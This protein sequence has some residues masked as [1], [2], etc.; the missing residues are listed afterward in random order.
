MLIDSHLRLASDDSVIQ[1]IVIGF[2]RN[3]DKANVSFVII[4]SEESEQYPH[5]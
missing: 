1:K 3:A 5:P 2:G 4:R